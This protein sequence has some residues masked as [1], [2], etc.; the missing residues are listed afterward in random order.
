VRWFRQREARGGVLH[1]SFV[2]RIIDMWTRTS[3]RNLLTLLA[4]VFLSLA[5]APARSAAETPMKPKPAKDPGAPPE[6]RPPPAKKEDFRYDGK[7]FDYWGTCL[8]TELKAERRLE[9]LEAVKAF[10]A[11]GYGK[12]SARAILEMAKTFKADLTDK[13]QEVFTKAF[14]VFRDIAEANKS[15]LVAAL[16]DPNRQARR[17]AVGV[18]ACYVKSIPKEAASGII[19][20]I[21]EDEKDDKWGAVPALAK[22]DGIES[23]LNK[24]LQDEKKAKKF[25]EALTEI[26]EKEAEAGLAIL[27]ADDKDKKE[28]A[29]V[30]MSA[31][32]MAASLLGEM[33]PAAK[34]AVPCLL[35]CL[36]KGIEF[37]VPFNIAPLASAEALGKIGAEPDLVIPALIDALKQNRQSLTGE[38]LTGN[39][40]L[41]TCAAY[42]LGRF[43]TRAKSAAPALRDILANKEMTVSLAAII[44][45][46]NI[47]EDTRKA[48]P[49]VIEAIK[50]S[51]RSDRIKVYQSFQQKGDRRLQGCV[52]V[53][54]SAFEQIPTDRTEI[55]SALGQLGPLAKDAVD[56]LT[57]ALDDNNPKVQRAAREALQRIKKE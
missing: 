53:L 22:I 18:L 44:A 2:E 7:N 11:N 57:K 36:K 49:V 29:L 21:V 40:A 10:T 48:V 14:L 23:L 17:F 26:L 50:K 45:L 16:G 39:D 15:M 5:T 35:K 33:G 47:G 25:V 27:F 31:P 55:A 46:D 41:R 3:S 9:A 24:E 1:S 13:D 32:P 42:S 12:E 38:K 4:I 8:R 34:D 6:D 51:D 54:I 20:V 56:C 52:P 19:R 43:G 28:R 30:I 37:S